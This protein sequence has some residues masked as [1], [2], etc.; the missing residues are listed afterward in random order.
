MKS[1]LMTFLSMVAVIVWGGATTHAAVYNVSTSLGNDANSCTQATSTFVL[2]AADLSK[3]NFKLCQ[4]PDSATVIEVSISADT[5]TPAVVTG[6]FRPNGG[7]TV[8]LNTS[9]LSAASGAFA[10]TKVS[11]VPAGSGTTSVNGTTTCSTTLSN[12]SLSKG[13]WIQLNSGSASTATDIQVG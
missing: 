1:V 10:C 12:T 7:T 3:T 8:A 5:G 13:D 6:R 2:P 9:L 4:V 11:G